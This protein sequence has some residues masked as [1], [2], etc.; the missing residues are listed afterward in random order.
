MY[1]IYHFFKSVVDKKGQLRTV[2]DLR[3]FP[4]DNSL[5]SCRSDG[6]FPDIALRLNK[7]REDFSGGELIEIKDSKSYSIPSFNSTLPTGSK[8]ISEIVGSESDIKHQMEKAE[9]DIFSLVDR[10]VYYFIRG[11]KKGNLKVCLVHGSFFETVRVEELIKGAFAQVLEERLKE[12]GEKL[13]DEVKA[14]LVSIFSKQ[15]NFKKVRDVQKASVKLRFRIM[16][17]VKSEGNVLNSK[18]YRDILDNSLNLIV[19]CHDLDEEK[20]QDERMEEVFGKKRLSNLHRVKVKHPLNG[21]FI[22]FQTLI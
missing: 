1:S 22:A 3:L 4:F 18:Q 21:Y 19:P 5:L 8:K 9:D 20:L 12:T 14:K 6:K 7:H 16:T 11:W 17:E 2:E 15:N 10:D 13:P